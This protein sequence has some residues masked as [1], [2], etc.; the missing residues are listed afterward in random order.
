MSKEH[1]SLSDEVSLAR[2]QE[3]TGII[4]SIKSLDMGSFHLIETN[5]TPKVMAEISPKKSI[6]RFVEVKITLRSYI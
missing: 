1:I 3:A 4:D 6:R 2:I 5:M